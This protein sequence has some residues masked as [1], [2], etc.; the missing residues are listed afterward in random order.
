MTSNR[1]HL[2]PGSSLQGQGPAEH[3]RPVVGSDRLAEPHQEPA[4]PT[5]PGAL[6][7]PSQGE[8]APGPVQL[9]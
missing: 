1:V 5:S 3:G 2:P 4:A 6:P 8:T 7:L 9:S